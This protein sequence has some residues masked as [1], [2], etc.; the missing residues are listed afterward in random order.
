MC[1]YVYVYLYV[2]LSVS[3]LYIPYLS[4][5]LSVNLLLYLSLQYRFIYLSVSDAFSYYL[6]LTKHNLQSRH[7]TVDTGNGT[8]SI[9]Y[10]RVALPCTLL[11]VWLEP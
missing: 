7:K 8:Y 10:S 2:F 1:V 3:I 11:P 9:E 4:V 6:L 5:Y